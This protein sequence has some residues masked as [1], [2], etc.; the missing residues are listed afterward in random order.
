[1]TLSRIAVADT[2]FQRVEI[3]KSDRQ[4]EFRVAGAIHAWWHR[5]RFLTGLAWDNLAAACFLRPAGPPRSVLML[6]LA[7]GTTF[8]VLRHLLPEVS[9]TAVDIDPSIVDLARQH[10]RLDDTGA[11]VHLADAYEWLKTN[12]RKFDVVIDDVY[13]AGKT[14]VFRPQAWNPEHLATLKRA[15][16]PGGLL[17][18]NLVT[19][20]GHRTMQSHVRNVLKDAF[21]S[22]RSVTTPDS[23]N[24]TLAAGDA[25]LSGS[26]VA[27][28]R[29]RFP[30][31]RDR[32]LWDKLRVRKL[33]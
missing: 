9:L 33:G 19:G 17:T 25:V 14:D 29:G 22:V 12:R 23:L 11:E 15:V 13:L 10:M 8:R 3:W 24:E 27:A 26:A 2:A 5:D 28:W 4:V 18:A 6:G 21:P 30:T 1:M 16:A 20:K 32:V 7:G 31:H